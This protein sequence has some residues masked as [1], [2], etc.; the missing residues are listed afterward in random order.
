M[1]LEEIEWGCLCRPAFLWHALCDLKASLL[2]FP[3]SDWIP[4]PSPIRVYSRV[5]F[6]Q[7]C[8][9]SVSPHFIPRHSIGKSVDS[10]SLK[11]VSKR[12]QSSPGPAVFCKFQCISISQLSLAWI[13][14]SNKTF[15][16][17]R[18]SVFLDILIM[19]R[20]SEMS[21]DQICCDGSR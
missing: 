7:C 10:S 11:A 12:S 8:L 21:L 17:F 16:N 13:V 6:Y 3:L 19:S 15:L 9:F 1:C 20:Y 18:N 4:S 5:V 14:K 2:S